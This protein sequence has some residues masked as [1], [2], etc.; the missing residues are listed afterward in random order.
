MKQTAMIFIINSVY[1]IV[2]AGRVIENGSI[3]MHYNYINVFVY[4]Y[5]YKLVNTYSIYI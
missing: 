5:F 3:F 2:S 1:Q 4:V